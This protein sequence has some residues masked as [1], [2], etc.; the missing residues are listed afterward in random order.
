MTAS[1]DNCPSVPNT[2][3]ADG[4]H[5]GVGDACDVCPLDNP[6]DTDGDGVCDSSDACPGFDD[7][8]D[9]DG[10]DVPDGCD[11]C[12][13]SDDLAPGALSDD[14]GD[15]VINC[16]DI[17][18]GADDDVYGPDCEE[19]IPAASTWGLLILTLLL[20]AAAK[21]AFRYERRFA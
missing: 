9:V 19:A 17:C 15:G 21:V 6:D 20:L 14:D 8:F 1:C 5:D 16:N 2:G 18:P 3:Q 11:V 12:P 10:A 4:D 13:Q 7:A